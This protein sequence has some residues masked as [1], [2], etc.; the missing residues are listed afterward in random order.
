[1]ATTGNVKGNLLGLYIS[2]DG[3]TNYTLV[4]S[5]TSAS[6]SISNDTYD[7]T[8]KANSGRR[9][10]LYAQ[11]TATI[12]AEGFVKYYDTY[13]SED[14]R[15][16]VLG[17]TDNTDYLAKFS[18]GVTGDKEVYF[19]CVVT[20]FEEQAAVNEIATFSITLESTGAITE[21]TV[22]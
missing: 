19:Q 22:S 5:A 4:G 21:G 13:G 8:T 2:T 1:M 7:V 20:S 11:Q 6:L 16:V 10:L 3:G 9:E 12:S 14:L 15:T 18:S 17:G